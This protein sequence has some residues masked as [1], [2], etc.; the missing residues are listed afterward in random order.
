MKAL[1]MALIMGAPPLSVQP[2]LQVVETKARE[3]A[4]EHRKGVT[5]GDEG[6][7][8]PS[9]LGI[10]CGEHSLSESKAI[11]RRTAAE[12]TPAKFKCCSPPPPRPLPCLSSSFLAC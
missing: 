11:H 8:I 7:F 10:G 2:F 12:L 6:R 3:D 1:D 5:V 9:V 4:K